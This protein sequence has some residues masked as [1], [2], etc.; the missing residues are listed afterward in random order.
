MCTSSR[1][2][3]LMKESKALTKHQI[4]SEATRSALLEAAEAIF[5]RDGY[6]R[7]QID[8]IAKES[9]RTRGA[10]YN[11]YKTKE[12]L[13]FAVQERRIEG[14]IRYTRELHSRAESDGFH[15]RWKAIRG[16][17]SGFQ[18]DQSEILDLELKLYG[19]RHPEAVK[20][21]QERYR[22]LFSVSEFT[23]YL[24]LTQKPGRSRLDSRV[25][26]LAAIKSG[27]ILSMKFLPDQL[28]PKEVRLILQ[29]LFEG[30]FREDE[31][32]SEAEAPRKKKDSSSRKG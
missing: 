5:A 23:K 24:G 27:L 28:P 4:K 19:L 2:I 16:T 20:E 12:Q 30:L 14:A 8:E 17:F 3:T 21:W 10:V 25:T 11:Q 7:A 1:T 15:A 18:D 26:A 32:P 29:E 9:G 22:R 31:I 13:F 6:E